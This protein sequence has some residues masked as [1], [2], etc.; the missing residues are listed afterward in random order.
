MSGYRDKHADVCN[1]GVYPTVTVR[2]IMYA[3]KMKP[4]KKEQ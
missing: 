3:L 2:Q 4:L 1:R